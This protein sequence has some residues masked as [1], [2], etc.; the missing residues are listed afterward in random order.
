MD[1]KRTRG[2]LRKKIMLLLNDSIY[3]FAIAVRN[4]VLYVV[5]ES[6][7]EYYDWG[8]PVRPGS[9]SWDAFVASLY[10]GPTLG[11][12]TYMPLILRKK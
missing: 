11:N 4:N 5:G 7:V 2:D 8:T 10:V 12:Q 6:H 3:G 9:G 1:K